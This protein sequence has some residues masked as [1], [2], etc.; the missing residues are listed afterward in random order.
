MH[1]YFFNVGQGDSELIDY[2]GVQILVDGGPDARILERLSEILPVEDR[3]L[4]AIV[5]SHPHQDHFAGLNDV[6]RAYRVGVFI[7]SGFSHETQQ[8]RHFQEAVADSGVRRVALRK[9]DRLRF[10]DLALEVVAPP[11]SGRQRSA[12]EIHDNTVVFLLKKDDFSGI[13]TGDINFKVEKQLLAADNR[14]LQA[15][16]LKVSHHGSDKSTSREFLAA[17]RP[18]VAV[19]EAGRNNRYGHPKPALLQ[20]LGEAGA[21]VYRT[22]QD[23]TVRMT[24]ED[25]R[26]NISRKKD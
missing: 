26:L 18:Q 12:R 4:D 6:L 13:F 7:D 15:H 22:D 3:Y 23:G 2:R 24:L 20:R 1:L 10:R 17:V 19:I 11:V 25:G 5:L 21:K 14:N 8:Y 16:L 9:G